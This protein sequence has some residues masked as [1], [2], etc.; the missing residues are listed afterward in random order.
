[1]LLSILAAATGRRPEDAAAE[2]SQYGPQNADGG[3]AVVQLAAPS[4]AQFAQPA[5]DPCQ[6]SRV[7]G[8]GRGSPPALAVPVL[9]PA[10]TGIAPTDSRNPLTGRRFRRPGRPPAGPSTTPRAGGAPSLRRWPRG[11]S[12]P[13]RASAGRG[14]DSAG[15]APPC[16]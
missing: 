6:T 2:Y 15:P 3:E 10:R 8:L 12:R 4:Q 13:A 11:G 14:S 5:A 9:P 16:A 7:L 1:N